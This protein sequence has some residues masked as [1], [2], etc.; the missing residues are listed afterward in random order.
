MAIRNT[1]DS[2]VSAP[3]NIVLWLKAFGRGNA[4]RG[5]RSA[6]EYLAA[7]PVEELRKIALVDAREKSAEEIPDIF[8]GSDRG[9]PSAPQAAPRRGLA[10]LVPNPSYSEKE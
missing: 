3:R 6:V 8:R 9:M 5:L 7:L 10:S 1:T 2:A 4:R